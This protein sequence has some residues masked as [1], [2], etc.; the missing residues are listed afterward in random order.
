[1]RGAAVGAE[2]PDVENSE[3]VET[4]QLGCEVKPRLSRVAVQMLRWLRHS[5]ARAGSG[6]LRAGRLPGLPFSRRRCGCSG[7]GPGT[8][9]SSVGPI[10]H[11]LLRL[12]SEVRL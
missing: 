4:V 6:G 7:G 3:R 9:A 11:V 12:G 1:M 5:S 8:K 2:R 10:Y